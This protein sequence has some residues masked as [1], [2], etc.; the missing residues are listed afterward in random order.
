MPDPQYIA[1]ALAIAFAITFALRAA[2]FA[3]LG[4]LRSSKL[5]SAMALWM[6][7]GLLAILAAST[8]RNTVQADPSS[9]LK[10]ALSVAVTSA[11]HLA[12]GRRTLLSVGLG[13]LCFAALTNLL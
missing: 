8:F 12:F 1:A 2:P 11:A 9:F 4:A 7:A 13:T 10:A 6:P 3:V 5:V